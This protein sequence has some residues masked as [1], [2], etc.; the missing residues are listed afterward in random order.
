MRPCQRRAR[1]CGHL[2]VCWWS[3]N[4]MASQYAQHASH[5]VMNITRCMQAH[6]RNM[7]SVQ[8]AVFSA[9]QPACRPIYGS[10]AAATDRGLC[11]TEARGI[12]NARSVPGCLQWRRLLYQRDARQCSRLS[13]VLQLALQCRAPSKAC[14]A[15][16][17][18]QHNRPATAI[19]ICS[20]SD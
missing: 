19:A 9:S 1:H 20:Q 6:C 18:P 12:H 3:H 17:K 8:P 7:L 11:A 2:Q 14:C 16:A 15:P 10:K 13:L 4:C 5:N